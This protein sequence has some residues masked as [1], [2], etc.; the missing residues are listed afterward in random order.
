MNRV[1]ITLAALPLA[2]YAAQAE[3]TKPSTI[4]TAK[5]VNKAGQ[6]GLADVELGKP[7]QIQRES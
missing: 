4:T 7:K 2:I 3:E 1:L 5:F 6:G